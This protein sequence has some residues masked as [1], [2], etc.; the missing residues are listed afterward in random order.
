MS[1]SSF[2]GVPSTVLLPALRSE[3]RHVSGPHPIE[4]DLTSKAGFGIVS[5]NVGDDIDTL[6]DMGAI[7]KALFECRLYPSLE[8]SQVFSIR[9]IIIDN[10]SKIVTV[11]GNVLE[12]L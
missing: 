3:W 2:W 10:D 4:I 7:T 12:K 9:S 1:D 6:V 8:N 11:V 5:S